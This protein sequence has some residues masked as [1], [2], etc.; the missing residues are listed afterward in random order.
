MLGL[1]ASAELVGR[2]VIETLIHPDDRDRMQ[3]FAASH[4]FGERAGPL[5]VRW[6]RGDGSA[7]DV[8]ASATPIVFDGA[9]ARLV[10][11]RDV[12]DLLRVEA[13]Q[14]RA[15]EC[16]R[17]SEER[18]RLLFDA[19]PLPITLI[20]VETL[21]FVAANDAALAMYGYDRDEFLALRLTDVKVEE[22]L[23]LTR[24]VSAMRVDPIES[25]GD[26]RGCKR[27]RCKGGAAGDVENASHPVMIDG[28]R[29]I[30][31]I[32]ANVTE[33]RRVEEQLRQSQKMDAIGRLA[34]GIAHDFNNMLAVVLAA[35]D[36]AATDL[37][38]DHPAQQDLKDI[39]AAAERAAALTRQLLTFS[40]RQPSCPRTLS[41][42]AVVSQ[43]EKMLCRII[44]EDVFLR[45]ALQPGIS[46]I[47][48]DPGQLDQVVMN[49][50]VNARDAMPQGGC[51][52][53]ATRDEVVR[54]A[55]AAALGVAPGGYSVLSV[56][57]TG[58]GMSAET[59]ARLFEPFFT[60]KEVGK[61]TGLGLATVFGIAKANGGTVSVES[62]PGRGACFTVFFP[63]AEGAVEG[64]VRAAPPARGS[65]CI[66]VVE[67]D[68]PVRRVVAKMLASGGY[69]VHQARNGEV[70]L[71]LL[72]SGRRFDLVL[73]DLVMPDM[74]GRTM[75]QAA[76]ASNPAT[77]V[78]FMSGYTEHAALRGASSEVDEHLIHKPFTVVDLTAA[79]RRVLD[80]QR[81][82]APFRAPSGL[83]PAIG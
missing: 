18:Y 39:L 79:V 80:G 37:G 46:T 13:E 53:I 5:E 74:D 67:D 81:P 51:L 6:V 50:V 43:L 69:E 14:V 25:F 77:R 10:V 56:T 82:S 34:G 58:V 16:L 29:T 41:L 23:E 28:R 49:L 57:D 70:V 52:T 7:L 55:A 21:R 26:W 65:E 71:E 1:E 54:G 64:P 24:G 30:V 12:T 22:D 38:E 35:A 73:S 2:P 19:C 59:R 15:A 63:C 4:P 31:A 72:E 40:R 32:G 75:V 27:H 20:D 76:R 42:N 78:L 66:L 47:S 36:M 45:T 33:K 8:R 62:E 9:P 60:T 48:C 83:P 44:G 3:R 68:E 61:G 11:A 17:A